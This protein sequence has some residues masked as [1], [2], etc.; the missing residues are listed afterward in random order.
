MKIDTEN[1]YVKYGLIAGGLYVGYKLI[2]FFAGSITSVASATNEVKN[3]TAKGVKPTYPDSN[4][5]QWA[6]SIVSAGFNTLGTNEQAI[7]AIFNKM[8][9]D[10]DVAKLIVA[11]GVQR[12]EFSFQKVPLGAWLSSELDSDELE[13]INKILRNKNIKYQF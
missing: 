9:N 12:V 10:L 13:V 3:L 4:Y 8:V 2:Q 6:S 5:S 7:Y 1:K 11:F